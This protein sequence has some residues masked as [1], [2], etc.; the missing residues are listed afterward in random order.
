MRRGAPLPRES[1]PSAEIVLFDPTH[2]HPSLRKLRFEDAQNALCTHFKFFTDVRSV[3]AIHACFEN[4]LKIEIRAWRV[5]GRVVI[6]IGHNKQIA[7]GS[8]FR[9]PWGDFPQM[10]CDT[11]ART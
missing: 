8:V 2:E 4:G 1:T 9:S 11:Q 10:L 3:T 7:F 5:H 6:P